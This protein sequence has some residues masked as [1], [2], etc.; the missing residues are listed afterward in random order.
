MVIG[1]IDFSQID[2]VWGLSKGGDAGVATALIQGGAEVA[3]AIK[4]RVSANC[5]LMTFENGTFAMETSS[6]AR[7][8]LRA[9]NR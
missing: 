6:E 7:L 4:D 1:A 3:A 5:R 9:S 2:R 8:A